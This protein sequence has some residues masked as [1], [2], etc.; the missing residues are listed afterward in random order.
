MSFISQQGVITPPLTAGGV[1]YGNGS[2]AFMTGAGTVGQVLTSAGAGAPV[3]GAGGGLNLI[4]SQTITTAVASVN[5]TSGINSTYDNYYVVFS[6]FKVQVGGRLRLRLRQGTTFVTADYATFEIDAGS[7]GSIGS[8]GSTTKTVLMQTRGTPDTS[9]TFS[10]YFTLQSVNNTTRRSPAA[11][12]YIGMLCDTGITMSSGLFTGT[13][14]VAGAIT[15][16]QF[17]S[18]SGNLTAG[19]VALYGM[20]K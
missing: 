15:G 10:G 17:L 9:S 18:D 1:A 2:N 12:G 13:V 11:N 4:S 19:T 7:G 16:F 8:S 14:D 20:A 3:W 6:N 5:F